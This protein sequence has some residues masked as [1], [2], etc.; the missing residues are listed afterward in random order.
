MS[1]LHVELEDEVVAL[2]EELHQ[3]VEETACQ[4]IIFELYRR[5]LLSSGKAAQI[6]EMNR[7]DFIQLASSVGI[8]Y[9]AMSRDEWEKERKSS[10]SL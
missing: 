7:T 10:E 3:P 8:P 6:L 1:A 9:L 4:L 5:G 2:L